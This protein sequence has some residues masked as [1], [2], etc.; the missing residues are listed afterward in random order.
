MPMRSHIHY[1][2]SSVGDGAARKNACRR[3][4]RAVVGAASLIAVVVSGGAAGRVHA[5]KAGDTLD[6]ISRKYGVS[7]S[8]LA[9]ANAISNP[10]Y[11]QAGQKITLPAPGSAPASGARV[12]AQPVKDTQARASTASPSTGRKVQVPASRAG[13]RPVFA[14]YAKAAGVPADLAMALA[15]QESGWQTHRVSSTQAVGVMQLMPD[16]VEFVS[17]I[18]L[19]QGANLD[20]HDPV[21]N[22]RMGTRFVRYLLDRNG[23]HVDTALASYYQGLR[24]VR[25]RG[26]FPE[27]R[28]F[29]ANVKALRPRF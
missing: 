1:M 23:G 6:G 8:A 9:Q 19:R 24:S 17:R 21:A 10:D 28:R 26:I 14:Q 18:L 20:P 29:V 25:E 16:T 15:W 13:L 2:R 4:G 7:V 5:V 27:T 12:M 3:G 11:I 22:I